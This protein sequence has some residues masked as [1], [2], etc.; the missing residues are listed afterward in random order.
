MANPQILHVEVVYARRDVQQLAA[1]ELEAGATAC[2]ALHLSGLL[3]KFPE[4]ELT[5]CKLGIF[6]RIVG[7]QQVL[8]DGDRVEIYREL[9]TDPKRARRERA[10]TQR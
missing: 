1:L 8:R 3:Q 4:I 7:P 10:L 9:P 6:G 5:T 2:D